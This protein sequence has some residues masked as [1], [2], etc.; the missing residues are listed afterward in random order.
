MDYDGCEEEKEKDGMDDSSSSSGDDD[1][2]DGEE[3]EK[4]GDGRKQQQRSP[5]KLKLRVGRRHK[6]S[7]KYF[8]AL[9]CLAIDIS[10][11]EA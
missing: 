6:E 9:D 5:N 8:P 2:D 10:A 11:C 7:F 4:E 1:D 3:E